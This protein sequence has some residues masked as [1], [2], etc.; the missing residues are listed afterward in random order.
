MLKRTDRASTGKRK[1][2]AW[3]GG[4]PREIVSPRE[5]QRA[6]AAMTRREKRHMRSSDA[7]AVARRRMPWM[8]IEK[9]YVFEGPGGRVGLPELFEGRPQLIL[10][11]F[12]FGPEVEGWPGKGCVGCSMVADQI[13]HLDHL[14]AR[15][16]TFAM[17][18]AAP[19][20]DI[21]RLRARYGWTRWP[22]Y[23]GTE[24]FNRDLDVSD[25]SG[26]SFG[27]NVFYRDGRDVYRTHFVARRG[28]EAF[29]TSW[30]FLDVVPLGRQETWQVAPPGTPQSPPYEW[31]R[32]HGEYDPEV[33][34]RAIEARAPA[35]PRRSTS[36]EQHRRLEAERRGTADHDRH[37]RGEQE[38]R[39]GLGCH[40]A[41]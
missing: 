1:T 8:K 27:M 9:D 10:Y 18:S 6:R 2:T 4:I 40:V 31:W 21:L 41:D 39:E 23:S 36:G 26:N 28:I 33:V 38:L 24:E 22:W 15:G 20:E 17:V 14:H 13:C 29:G 5:W 32:R 37:G 35:L 25:E 12:M 30:S 3:I 7:V 16:V 19:L 11:H 34:G